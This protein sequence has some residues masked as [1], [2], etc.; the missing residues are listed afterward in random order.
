[1]TDTFTLTTDPLYPWSSPGHGIS[2]LLVVALVL[3]GLTLWAYLGV[4]GASSRR[5]FIVLC[6]RFLALFLAILAILRP[7]IASR[8]DLKTPST[9]I[10]L[11]DKS[12]SMTIH[13]ASGNMSRY[14]ALKKV[15]QLSE[16]ALKQ[17]TED[18]NVTVV[19]KAFGEG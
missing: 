2:A 18:Q 9:L 4:T 16:P 8:D 14:D 1:M 11:V 13:D 15:L 10:I 12:E 5:V 19:I 7:A 17:L 3:G 6:L